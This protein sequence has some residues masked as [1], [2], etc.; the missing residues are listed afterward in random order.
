MAGRP[1]GHSHSAMGIKDPRRALVDRLNAEVAS[2]TPSL[3]R[4]R[5]N[6][7]ASAA[8]RASRKREGGRVY[9]VRFLSACGRVSFVK[10]GVSG[11]ELA[12]RFQADWENY[13]FE[14]LMESEWMDGRDALALEQALHHAYRRRRYRPPI[15]LATGNT[16]CYQFGDELNDLIE[17][18]RAGRRGGVDPCKIDALSSTLSRS[19]R[20]GGGS[21][22]VERHLAK[23]NVGGS[24]PLRRSKTRGKQTSRQL[25]RRIQEDQ[26]KQAEYLRSVR[27]PV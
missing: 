9:V 2:V 15:P 3:R 20:S 18:V 10:I 14:C 6:T 26:A 4:H 16:E 8:K 13:S 23:V 24:S 12:A 21:S 17:I 19:T 1:K 7:P 11:M 27:N 22:G 5:E 25:K